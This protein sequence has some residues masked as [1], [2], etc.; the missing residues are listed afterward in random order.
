MKTSSDR[1]SPIAHLLCRIGCLAAW[2]CLETSLWGATIVMMDPNVDYGDDGRNPC[3]RGDRN[4]DCL[5]VSYLRDQPRDATDPI[6]RAAWNAWNDSQPADR[7]WTLTNGGSLNGAFL[8]TKFDTFN[9]C[10]SPGGVEIRARYA[11]EA[12]NLGQLVWVQGIQTNRR[13][14]VFVPHDA[15]PLPEMHLMDVGTG[16]LRNE[17]PAPAYPL[18]YSNGQ[19]Y[20]KAT[21]YCLHEREVYFRATALLAN[22]DYRT[23]T[24]TTYEG[25]SW[26][27]SVLCVHR[28]VPAPGPL[29]LGALAGV[30]ACRRRRVA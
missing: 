11:S 30:F 28:D 24:L 12:E 4:D 9:P 17:W 6:F 10:P 5:I 16:R 26:G 22:I 21:A 8:I 25:F 14:G 19:F 27:F 1:P 3:P 20:D 18:Q 29:A 7:R 15:P 23:R 2:T 13:A